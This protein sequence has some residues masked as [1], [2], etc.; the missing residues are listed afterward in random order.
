MLYSEFTLWLYNTIDKLQE[1]MRFFV[2]LGLFMGI[3]LL[4]VGLVWLCKKQKTKKKNN[5]K[6]CRIMSIMV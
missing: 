6:Y 3:P 2:Y 1:P 5:V 4:L